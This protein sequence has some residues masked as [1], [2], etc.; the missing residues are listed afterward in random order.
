M[1]AKTFA[2]GFV[3]TLFA[4]TLSSATADQ[5]VCFNDKKWCQQLKPPGV[6]PEVETRV[7]G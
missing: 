7:K 2:I 4:G 6:D 1:L 3:V 5:I